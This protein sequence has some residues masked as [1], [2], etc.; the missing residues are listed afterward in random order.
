M[1]RVSHSSPC[2]GDEEVQAVSG[3]LRSGQIAQGREVEALETECAAFVGR[4]YAVAV[5]SGTSALHLALAALGVGPGKRVATPSYACAALITAVQM[6]RAEPAL[7]DVD[8]GGNLD[9]AAVP[10]GVDVVIVPH[11][12][13][14][15]ARLPQARCCIEDIAQSIGGATGRAGAITVASFYATKMLTTGEGGMLLTDDEGIAEFASDRRDYDHRDD[16]QPRYNYKMTDMQ[17]AM[18]RVQ[19]RRLPGFVARRRQIAEQYSSGLAGLPI[20][21][22][23]YGDRH[24]YFRYVIAT[25]RRDALEQHL[26]EHGIEAKRPVHRPAHHAL[27]GAFPGADRCHREFLSLPIYPS[28]V[29]GQIDHVIESTRGFFG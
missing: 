3:V 2:V 10:D 16:F 20:R 4:R 18:G 1:I 13:G 6:C 14:A 29:D 15:E 24:V 26:R 28:L 8:S 22:P 11:L 5:N 12:F 21:L 7:C 17:A 19:L 23:G 25:D 27:G 9:C